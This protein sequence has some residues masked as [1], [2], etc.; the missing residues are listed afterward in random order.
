MKK[1]VNIK[2]ADENNDNND[3]NFSK[4]IADYLKSQQDAK[5][6]AKDDASVND[7]PNK[8]INLSAFTQNKQ[9]RQRVTGLRSIGDTRSRVKGSIRNRSRNTKKA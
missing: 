2:P 9:T 3:N 6:N 8:P 5:D 4:L 1:T 7:K